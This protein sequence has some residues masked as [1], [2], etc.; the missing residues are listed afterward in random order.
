MDSVGARGR[1]ALQRKQRPNAKVGGVMSPVGKKS[2]TCLE[3]VSGRIRLL[4]QC[5][6]PLLLLSGQ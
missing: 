5:A 3:W 1:G 2:E 4:L 6:S